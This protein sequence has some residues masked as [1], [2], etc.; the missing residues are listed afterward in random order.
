[1]RLVMIWPLL[2]R[3]TTPGCATKTGSRRPWTSAVFT[4]TWHHRHQPKASTLG[5][6]ASPANTVAAVRLMMMMMTAQKSAKAEASRR[7]LLWDDVQIH[8]VVKRSCV[9]VLNMAS[10]SGPPRQKC[11]Q[12]LL[13]FGSKYTGKL[14]KTVI[15]LSTITVHNPYW[16]RKVP[17]IAPPL[18]VP[19]KKAFQLQGGPDVTFVYKTCLYKASFDGWHDVS[20]LYADTWVL[21]SPAAFSWLRYYTVFRKKP[22]FVFFYNV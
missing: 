3:T 19:M 18:D 13:S 9:A 4:S 7:Q 14:K 2:I 10:G 11:R 5:G 1:M 15:P 21:S 6:L 17:R 8:V 16:A 22:P 12:T 20:Y